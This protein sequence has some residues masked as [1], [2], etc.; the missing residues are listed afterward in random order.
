MIELQGHLTRGWKPDEISV[1]S[2]LI[3]I[4]IQPPQKIA[5]SRFLRRSIFKK[6]VKSHCAGQDRIQR[7]VEQEAFARVVTFQ[8]NIERLLRERLRK[9]LANSSAQECRGDRNSNEA[10]FHIIGLGFGLAKSRMVS[11]QPSVR[12]V[13]VRPA[14]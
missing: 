9:A 6:T 8:D 13:A 10:V 4:E 1:H 11:F 12:T 3:A 7:Q 5:S 2:L 14:P